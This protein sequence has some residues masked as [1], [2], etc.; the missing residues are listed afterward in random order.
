MAQHTSEYIPVQADTSSPSPK[1][2]EI[3][4]QH[5][6]AQVTMALS[7]LDSRYKENIA[8]YA[9]ELH[10]YSHKIDTAHVNLDLAHKQKEPHDNALLAIEKEIDYELRLLHRL[11]EQW[12]QKTILISELKSE[13]G[14]L[15]STEQNN[16]LLPNKFK[17]LKRLQQEIE[18]LEL[19]LLKHELEK[20]N[21]LLKI[22]PIERE[23][24]TLQQQIGE[25][26]SQK[27]YIESSYLHRISQ[28]APA[29]QQAQ[30]PSDTVQ[31]TETNDTLS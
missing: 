21:I 8:A 2:G 31:D 25:L 9:Q 27:R 15:P 17:E 1:N 7:A 16:T 19:T 22:E 28:V 20:Q 23:I 14:H 11:T 10:N 29:Q 4:E 30:L 13:L 18:D 12:G 6:S 3:S 24:R 5:V 26:E